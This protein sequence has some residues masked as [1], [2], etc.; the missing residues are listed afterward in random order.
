MVITAKA[1][2]VDDDE[3]FD[4]SRKDGEK[5]DKKNPKL[6]GIMFGSIRK[7]I[8]ILAIGR[9][10]SFDK[11]KD[12]LICLNIAI[13]E[14]CS[15]QIIECLKAKNPKDCMAS[16]VCGKEKVMANCL[17]HLPDLPKK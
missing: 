16:L 9:Y 8:R 10:G 11:L 5:F 4:I 1:Q 3:Q 12:F 15:T 17:N 6:E 13:L 14:S 2:V 7:T